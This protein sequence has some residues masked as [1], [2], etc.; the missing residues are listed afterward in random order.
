MLCPG[1]LPPGSLWSS[2]DTQLARRKICL[3]TQP[4]LTPREWLVFVPFLFHI[5]SNPEDI[6][7][8]LSS[9]NENQAGVIPA[10]NKKHTNAKPF[11]WRTGH[12][13][14]T[15]VFSVNVQKLLLLLCSLQPYL[16]YWRVSNKPLEVAHCSLPKCS[17]GRNRYILK[18]VLLMKRVNIF[19]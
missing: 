10:Q 11:L 3:E 17:E 12:C 8:Y 2:P 1:C 5:M 14:Q 6:S 4:R 15:N 16:L 9:K 19:V 18:N 7:W 13:N